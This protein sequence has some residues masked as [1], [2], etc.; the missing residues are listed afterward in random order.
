MIL[1]EINKEKRRRLEKV[2]VMLHPRE[3]GKFIGEFLTS[4]VCMQ[5]SYYFV[6]LI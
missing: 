6:S 2:S 4:V 5:P 3:V 1:I